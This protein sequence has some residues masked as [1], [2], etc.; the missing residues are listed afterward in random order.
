MYVVDDE[1]DLKVR[2]SN[3]GGDSPMFHLTLDYQGSKLDLALTSDFGLSIWFQR[4]I[5]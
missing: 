4:R 1:L 5:E 3:V 2:F